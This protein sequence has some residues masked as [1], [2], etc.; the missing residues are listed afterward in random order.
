[1][2]PRC[3]EDWTS[4]CRCCED[5]VDGGIERPIAS[6]AT[7][8]VGRITH[9]LDVALSPGCGVAD[10]LSGFPSAGTKLCLTTSRVDRRTWCLCV[11]RPTIESDSSMR[12]VS[13]S[14]ERSIA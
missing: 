6:R 11:K 8:G 4:H 7:A 2:T 10:Q 3:H 13:A 5:S 12:A 14:S 1:M 9:C